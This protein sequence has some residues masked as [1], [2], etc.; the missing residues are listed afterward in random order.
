MAEQYDEARRALEQYVNVSEQTLSIPE[1]D[2][3]LDRKLDGEGEVLT[4]EF[5]QKPAPN[6]GPHA[7]MQGDQDEIAT[8]IRTFI[9]GSRVLNHYLHKPIEA[10]QLARRALSLLQTHV[11]LDN[12]V[13][14]EAGINAHKELTGFVLR[15]AGLA[16]WAVASEQL[17]PTERLLEQKEAL[18]LLQQSAHQDD[19]A[20]ETFL[21]LARLQAELNET[22][23]A[24]AN[25]RKAVELEPAAVEPWHLLALLLSCKRDYKAALRL[26]CVALDRIEA[27]WEYDQDLAN[28]EEPPLLAQEVKLCSELLSYDFPPR[29]TERAEAV[30]QLFV[31][32]NMLVEYVH[33]PLIA[34][35][36]KGDFCSFPTAH[37]KR[38]CPSAGTKCRR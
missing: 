34:I 27:D 37:R 32:H 30:F 10:D 12:T 21:A 9:A 26:A 16:R 2:K 20:A 25:A 13:L 28:K 3:R 33:G 5:D 11:K 29:A 24:M 14:D 35:A 8:V 22:A 18:A 1:T 4:D 7:G 17:A 31:T 15:G 38:C 23:A 19:Q 6:D 36:V